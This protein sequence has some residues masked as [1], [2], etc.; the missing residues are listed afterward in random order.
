MAILAGV[1]WYTDNTTFINPMGIGFTVL[2]GVLL[3]SLPRRYALV[4]VIALTC[5]MTMG[6]RILFFDLNFTMIR[7][8]ALFGWA[9]LIL[10]GEIRS[11]KWNAIDTALVWWTVSSVV[12]Y[13]LLWGTSEAFINRCGL[14]YNALGMYFLFRFLV[15]D[16]ND[17][18]RASKAAAF[19]I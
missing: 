10:R 3:I 13:T 6:Q 16:W 8:L 1:D 5:F 15:L 11:F 9:R 14:A 17:I 2:M 4:P 18:L 12:T 7:V 19:L